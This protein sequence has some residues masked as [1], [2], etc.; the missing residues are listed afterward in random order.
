MATQTLVTLDQFMDL[1]DQ[2]GV[3]LRELDEGRVIEMSHPSVLHGAIQANVAHLLLSCVERTGT[4]FLVSQNADF[5]LGTNIVRC[6]DVFLLRRSAYAVMEKV[7]GGAL[8]G[9]PDLAVEVVSPSDSAEDLDRKVHQYL[10]AGTTAVWV[11]YHETQHIMVH[12]RSGEILNI[13][14]GQTLEEP[15]VLPGERIP[16]DAIFSVIA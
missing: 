7:R 3:W 16:A 14:A 12:R 4:D 13:T 11:V 2:E 1:P 6:P 9:A 8:R 10:H 5:L 15:L